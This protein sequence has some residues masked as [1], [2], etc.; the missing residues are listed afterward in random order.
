MEGSEEAVVLR[1][2]LALSDGE[3]YFDTTARPHRPGT[4]PSIS[5]AAWIRI[6]W[7]W[8]HGGYMNAGI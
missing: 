5:L 6:A 4:A 2:S 7:I 3:R 1:F 8:L